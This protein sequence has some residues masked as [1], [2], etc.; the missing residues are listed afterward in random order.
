MATMVARKMSHTLGT[1]VLDIVYKKFN[2]LWRA[3]EEKIHHV[4]FMCM[5]LKS[6]NAA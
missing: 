6:Y 2:L 5:L 1:Y 3:I 4:E